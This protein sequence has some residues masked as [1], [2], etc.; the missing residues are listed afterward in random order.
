M[1]SIVKMLGLAFFATLAFSAIGAL[2]AGSA[3]ALLF[4][5]TNGV[6][7]ELF[8]VL[9]LNGAGKPAILETA[10]G[11][12][13]ECETVLAHGFILN[14][15]DEVDK[16]LFTFHKCKAFLSNCSSS[17]EPSGLITTL[18]LNALLVT[19]LNGHYG[20]LILGEKTKHLATYTC[21]TEK[22]VVEGTVVGEF[23]ETKAESEA[24]KAE[25][26]VE[27]KK[28][29]NPGEPAITSYWTLQGTAAPKLEATITGII[30]ESKVGSSETAVG[31]VS[32]LKPVKF[33]HTP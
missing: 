29:A 12:T 16:L 30:N 27:F 17:G 7:T 13:T 31:D 9:D 23:T 28:G 19:L 6:A 24:F 1:R 5:T 18:E 10:S 11:H 8:T 3:S 21:G 32:P 22:V 15:T 25:A 20:I 33:C 4:L 2:G 14:K 26:K